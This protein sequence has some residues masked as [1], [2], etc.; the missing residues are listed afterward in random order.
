MKTYFLSLA[1][2]VIV[3]SAPAAYAESY[4]LG[5]V[6]AIRLFEQSP[7]A[8]AAR[9]LIEREFA[10][11]DKQL[12]AQQKQLKALEDR[13]GKDGAIM[14]EQ[15]RSKLER[16]II[17]KKRDLKRGQDEFQ[18]DLNFRRNEELAKIQKDIIEAIQQVAKDNK[19]DMILSEGVIYANPRVDINDLVL[20]Y[21]KKK[22]GRS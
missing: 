10:P 15:E 3:L 19:F 1:L 20:E 8:D 13:L 14:S 2:A 6:N 16:D 22:S 17:N 12:I 7:Q 18:E 5:A 21:L 11:R 4:K 9:K